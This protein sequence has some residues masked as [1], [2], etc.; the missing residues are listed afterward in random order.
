MD[1]LINLLWPHDKLFGIEWH[2]WKVVGWLGNLLFFSRFLVQWY[3]SEKRKQVVIPV[4][5][6]WLSLG[7]SFLLFAYAAMYRRD[8]VF[9]FAYAFTWIPYVRNL[10]IHRREADARLTCPTC[11]QISRPEA[12]FC[13][14]CGVRLT[15]GNA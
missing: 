14:A 15:P 3:H 13:S 7:G 6:W 8:S 12:N 2:L 4:V 9:V 11:G 5:F 1:W 10:I